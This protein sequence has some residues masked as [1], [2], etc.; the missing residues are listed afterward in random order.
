MRP[1]SLAIFVAILL[2]PG[3]AFAAQG[4]SQAPPKSG[5]SGESSLGKAVDSN[6]AL[7]K[8]LADSG[9]DAAALVRNLKSYLAQFPDAPRAPEVY[10]AIVEACQQL[11]DNSCALEY[12]ELLIAVRPE[13]SDMMVLAIA[14]L[15]EKGDD[16]SL[17]RAAGYATR[18]IDR[19]EKTPLSEKP[20]RQS[21]A[22]WQKKQAQLRAALYCLRGQIENSQRN[23]DLA[24]KDLDTS[25]TLGPSAL[26]AEQLGEIA[27]TQKDFQKAIEEYSLAFALPDTGLA[28]APDRRDVRRKL[29]NVWR[30]VHGSELG[31][32]DEILAAYDRLASAPPG[33]DANPA[34]RNKDA[35]N[36]YEFVLSHP[37][38]SPFPLATLKGQILALSFW[39]T[40]CGPCRDLEPKFDQV[41]NNYLGNSKVAFFAVD[42]DEDRSLVPPFLARAKWN[43]SVVYADGLDDFLKVNF[44]PT[45]L[46][47][48]GNGKI[49]YCVTGPLPDSLAASLTSAIQRALAPAP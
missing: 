46:L 12:S 31:L 13:D 33:L 28:G 7:Q 25:Y 43:V 21:L 49:I 10:R 38:G 16:A 30:Q 11:D 6:A 48:D 41:A 17:A 4:A 8:A 35:K 39:A 3:L 15:Q 5:A 23:Y 14:L 42:T 20:P 45:V 36:I 2:A 22:D 34:A 9:N 40:W 29:G 47:L 1:L 44:L 37:D 32:G 27:E 18:V 24:V 26:A 19:V